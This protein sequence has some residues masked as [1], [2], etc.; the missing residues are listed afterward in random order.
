MT[1]VHDRSA[2]VPLPAAEPRCEPSGECVVRGK[3][4]RYSASLKAAA[5]QDFS[6]SAGGGTYTCDGFFLLHHV[7][8]PVNRPGRNLTRH[9]L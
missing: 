5:P 6:V 4:A 1:Y 3:C 7:L 2:S 9:D 8:A